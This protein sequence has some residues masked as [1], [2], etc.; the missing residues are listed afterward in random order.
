MAII[1]RFLIR[2]CSKSLLTADYADNTDKDQEFRSFL[3][4]RAHQFYQRL[5]FLR[6]SMFRMQYP[7]GKLES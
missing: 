6:L 2:P 5:N 4:I 7:F 1:E 3:C